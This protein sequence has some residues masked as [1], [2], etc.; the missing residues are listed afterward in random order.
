[1]VRGEVI[2]VYLDYTS[3][4]STTT[5]LTLRG[6]NAPY[7]TILSLSNTATDRWVYPQHAI[8]DYTGADV[9]YDGTHPLYTPFI[10][11]DYVTAV[12]TQSTWTTPTVRVY[13]YWK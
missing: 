9:T 10:L 1:M 5:D 12:I 4:I 7:D 8:Q 6:K 11:D 3:G 13:L 2:A